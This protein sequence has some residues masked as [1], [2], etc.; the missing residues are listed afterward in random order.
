[1]ASQTLLIATVA[2]VIGLI[3]GV[4]RGGT[5]SNLANADLQWW[6]LFFLGIG[7]V[8]LAD[9]APDLSIDFWLVELGAQGWPWSVSGCSW[10]SRYAISIWSGCRSSRSD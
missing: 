4:R 7:L 10:C 9:V 5:L 1:V 3:I 2:V 6:R 8:G